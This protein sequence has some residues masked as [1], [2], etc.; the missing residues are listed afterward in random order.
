MTEYSKDNRFPFH[1]GSRSVSICF[2]D[3]EDKYEL[4]FIWD[5]IIEKYPQLDA[6]Q[7]YAKVQEIQEMKSDDKVKFLKDASDKLLRNIKTLI[8]DED[9]IHM[10]HDKWGFGAY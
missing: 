4:D 10:L 6:E 3:H 9:F 7:F 2:D 1:S 5:K 8:S